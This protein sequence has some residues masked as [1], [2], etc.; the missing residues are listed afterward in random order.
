MA[1]EKFLFDDEEERR[2]L[3]F[4][5][6]M[7]EHHQESQVYFGFIECVKKYDI[8]TLKVKY[9]DIGYIVNIPDENNKATAL[10]YAA[11]SRSREIVQWLSKQDEIDYL[12]LDSFRRLPSIVAYE[13]GHDSVIGLYLAKK[14]H[15]QAEAQGIDIQTLLVR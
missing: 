14:E 8:E 3:A 7:Q 10:H 5:T 12:V 11:G 15:R 9:A 2:R 4:E 1:L 13:V 6:W